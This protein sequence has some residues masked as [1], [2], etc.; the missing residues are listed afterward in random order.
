[1]G[2]VGASGNLC[3]YPPLEI[4]HDTCPVNGTW[5]TVRLSPGIA[6]AQRQMKHLLSLKSHLLKRQNYL[7]ILHMLMSG[8]ISIWSKLTLL[9]ILPDNRGIL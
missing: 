4:A 9:I 8:Q 1:M 2:G 5:S 3:L 7:N 6:R